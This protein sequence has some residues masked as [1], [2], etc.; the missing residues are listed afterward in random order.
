[1]NTQD[2]HPQDRAAPRSG[3]RH[4]QLTKFIERAIDI[5]RELEFLCN[6]L[7]DFFDL[8]ADDDKP[9]V[10]TREDIDAC[11]E[12]TELVAELAHLCRDLQVADDL[13]QLKPNHN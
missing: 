10:L 11:E 12:V 5:G 6:Q 2:T 8:Y 3:Q 13:A 4:S 7:P 1:M 9:R